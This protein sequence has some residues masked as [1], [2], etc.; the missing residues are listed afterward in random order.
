M[1]KNT[2]IHTSTSPESNTK[3]RRIQEVYYVLYINC[4]GKNITF[5]QLRATKFMRNDPT[6][7][8][9]V[10]MITYN[11]INKK[12]PHLTIINFYI[13]VLFNIR[14]HFCVS[15]SKQPIN[16]AVK[17]FTKITC[18]NFYIL[19]QFNIQRHFS[20]NLSLV[21]Y[22]IAQDKNCLNIHNYTTQPSHVILQL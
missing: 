6:L 5:R 4:A 2:N 13:L 10:H 22:N 17:Y 3:L 14:R 21:T 8:Y 12:I 18:H 19:I 16:C 15:D 1:F 20:S 7:L 9:C 11:I